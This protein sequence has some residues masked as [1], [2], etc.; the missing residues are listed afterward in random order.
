M[1][2]KA[3]SFLKSLSY[4]VFA[5]IVTA[6]LVFIMTRRWLLAIGLGVLDSTVKLFVYFLHERMWLLIRFGRK[7]HPLEQF[8]VRRALTAQDKQAIET[9]LSEMGCLGENI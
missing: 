4:R 2:T 8:P 5:S 7:A 1:D 3:R 9:K 6:V